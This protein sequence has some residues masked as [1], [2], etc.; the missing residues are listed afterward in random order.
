MV[1]KEKKTSRETNSIGRR[2]KSEIRKYWEK[3]VEPLIQDS[4][5]S[6]MLT[7]EDYGIRVGP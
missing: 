6:E 5:K 1:N 7:A 2:N 4:I 3:R